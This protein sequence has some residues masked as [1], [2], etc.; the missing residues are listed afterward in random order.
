MKMGENQLEHYLKFFN[1]MRQDN[2]YDRGRATGSHHLMPEK[3]ARGCSICW[4][5]SFNNF[6]L[7]TLY[8]RAKDNVLSCHTTECFLIV[9]MTVFCVVQFCILIRLFP[10]NLL[11]TE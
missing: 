1:L 3:G 2:F 6:A 8:A 4:T 5:K 10:D 9:C 11:V 7:E